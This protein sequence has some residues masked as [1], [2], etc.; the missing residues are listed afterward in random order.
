MPHSGEFEFMMMESEWN[1]D[2]VESNKY[3]PFNSPFMSIA[4]VENI[5]QVKKK[6]KIRSKKPE[7]LSASAK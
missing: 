7:F 3:F 6:S 5:K 1:V 4:I 2:S